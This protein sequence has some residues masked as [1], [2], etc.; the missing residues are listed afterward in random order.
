M[1]DTPLITGIQQK[2]GM[3]SEQQNFPLRTQCFQMS[4]AQDSECF[5]CCYLGHN[6]SEVNVNFIPV[7][8]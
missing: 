6:P 7:N 3:Q 4:R 5:K 8:Y 1:A 2:S